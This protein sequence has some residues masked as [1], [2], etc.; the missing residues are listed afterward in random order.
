MI[1]NLNHYVR[2]K[3]TDLGRKIIEDTHIVGIVTDQNGQFI[4]QFWE[5]IELFGPHLHIGFDVPFSPDV[6]YLGPR[7]II[8]TRFE[9]EHPKNPEWKE[10]QPIQQGA[11]FHKCPECD[12]WRGVVQPH[13]P[14][15]SWA[16]TRASRP[17]G[18]SHIHSSRPSVLHPLDDS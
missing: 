9:Y 6:E 5:A 13:K 10:F 4:L 2:L 16:K 1:L 12:G 17:P 18:V 8:C 7:C 14:T 15:C 3:I 11:I